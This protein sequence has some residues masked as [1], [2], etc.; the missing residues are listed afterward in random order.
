MRFIRGYNAT[1]W[2]SYFGAIPYSEEGVCMNGQMMDVFHIV[3]GS[4][5]IISCWRI[6]RLSSESLF[7]LTHIRV[8]PLIYLISFI[9]GGLL[10]LSYGIIGLIHHW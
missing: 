4:T 5:L 9:I 8:N 3:L 2:T 7:A 1:K 10:F 6:S